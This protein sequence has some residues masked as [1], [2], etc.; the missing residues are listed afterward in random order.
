MSKYDDIHCPVCGGKMKLKFISRRAYDDCYVKNFTLCCEC[1]G[2]ETRMAR[3]NVEID[4][5]TADVIADKSELEKVASEL[6]AVKKSADLGG[7][8]KERGE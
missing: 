4:E 6:R 3:V 1:C 2:I 7:P 5:K 8:K